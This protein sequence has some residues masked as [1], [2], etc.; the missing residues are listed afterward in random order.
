MQSEASMTMHGRRC[1]R[2][3]AMSVY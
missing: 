3:T 1:G 2:N